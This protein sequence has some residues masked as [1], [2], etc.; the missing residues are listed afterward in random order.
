MKDVTRAPE[1]R[2]NRARLKGT[3][4]VRRHISHYGRCMSNSSPRWYDFDY[5]YLLRGCRIAY[6]S[7]PIPS[8][9]GAFYIL[10]APLDALVT[11]SSSSLPQHHSPS[12]SLSAT[13][14]RPPGPAPAAAP[15]PSHSYR[16]QPARQWLI[17]GPADAGHGGHD[18]WSRWPRSRVGSIRP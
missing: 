4:C 11:R 14:R 1:R 9:R 5:H 18:A 17:T 8:L 7:H 12:P 15:R 13:A 16:P 6:T 3:G 10:P 2:A